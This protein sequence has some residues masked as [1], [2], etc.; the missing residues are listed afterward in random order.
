M[1][2]G[3]VL[4]LVCVSPAVAAADVV[5]PPPDD[6]VLGAE[7]TVCHGLEYCRPLDCTSDAD[8]DGGEIC[9]TRD[10]CIETRTCGGRRLPDS[11]PPPSVASA[12]ATCSEACAEGTCETRNVCVPDGTPPGTDDGGCGC[13]VSGEP[14]GAGV[15]AL[16][17]SLGAALALAWRRRSAR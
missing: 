17:G 4:A 3:L 6:C 5:G 16:L 11:G 9:Q 8:C 12:T 1:R 2:A 13:R 7:G 14:P 15:L 10:L